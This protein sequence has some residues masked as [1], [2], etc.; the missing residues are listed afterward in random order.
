MKQFIIAAVIAFV[1]TISHVNAQ[2]DIVGHWEGKIKML[3]MNLDIQ[4]RVE[5]T[6]KSLNGFMSIP[7]QNLKDYQLPVFTFKKNKVLRITKSSW[8]RKF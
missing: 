1:F 8:N 5:K 2:N 6:K 4:I 3:T 7:S